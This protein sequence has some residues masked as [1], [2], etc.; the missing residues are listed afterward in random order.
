VEAQLFEYQ[1]VQT[2]GGV[3][4]G[5]VAAGGFDPAVKSLSDALARAGLE[6]ADVTVAAVD[7][8]PAIR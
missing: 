6:H 7:A 5:V 3:A 1:V 8:I 4:V 2:P